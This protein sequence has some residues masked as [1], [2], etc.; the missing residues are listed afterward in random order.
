LPG[1]VVEDHHGH[2]VGA[3]EVEDRPLGPDGAL[4][5]RLETRIERRL[6]AAWAIGAEARQ[7]HLGEVRCEQWRR[8]P[9]QAEAFRERVVR[10][11]A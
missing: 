3:V 9:G 5:L 11:T 2:V 10:P 1:L 7:H 6:D 8:R 4:H